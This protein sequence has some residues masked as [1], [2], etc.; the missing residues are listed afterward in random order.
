MINDLTNPSDIRD[1]FVR[2]TVRRLSAYTLEM[3]EAEDKLD[4]NESP[5][6][7]P[8]ELKR[9]IADRIAARPWNM[10]PDFD[11]QRI[12][13]AIA[14]AYGRD[15]QE[16]LA[17]NGSNEL[18]LAALTTFVSPG[19][20]VVIPEP[21]FTLYSKISTIL[22]GDIEPI[23]LDPSLGTL[24]IDA[25]V[26]AVSRSFEESRPPVVIL[27]SPNNPTGGALRD[28]ELDRLLT[29]GALVLLDRAYGEFVPDRYPT[30]HPRLVVFSTFSKAW[31]LAGLRVGWLS[32][33]VELV[34]E[35]RKCKLPYNLNIASEEAA[36]TLLGRPELREENAAFL[37][38]E[39]DRLFEMLATIAGVTPYP[40]F[41]NFVTFALDRDPKEVF[42]G[43]LGKGILVRDVTAYPRL[44]NALR[45]SVGTI[46][47]NDRFVEVLGRIVDE[48]PAQI[49]V[50]VPREELLAP[51]QTGVSVPRIGEM[52]DSARSE[53]PRRAAVRRETKETS[54]EVEV[55]L[56]GTGESDIDTPIGFLSHMLDVIARHG[57]IDLRVH[58]RGDV[59]I[60]YHHTVEDVALVLGEAI[61]TALGD[62]RGIRRFGHAYVPL[63]ESLARVV[64]DFAGRPFLVFD[65]PVDRE[66]L[67]IHKDFPFALVEEFFKSIAN[68]AGCALH[69][70]LIRGRNGH[71]AAEAIFK[72]FAVALRGAKEVVHSTVPST[73]G[74]I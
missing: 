58:A 2:E 12:R 34:A 43:L 13:E 54:I 33:S 15:P 32:G 66:M 69:I 10:Y 70:D 6:D 4:Q 19:T 9:E 68:R 14:R 27:C 23:P 61:A 52:S 17:G 62:K 7:V 30:A 46:E 8:A 64:I 56:D 40:S 31:G 47:Q 16:I 73:K 24:P 63:D 21:T 20:R 74:V 59:E 60:D 36:I 67:L 38:A 42:R 55:D 5:F 35:I 57:R 25:I 1:T 22:G 45:V 18:L 26:A 49:G 50:S 71:H 28:G 44:S 39:R 41:S 72:A 29:T 53:S 51:T 3:R 48:L 37:S 11:L 65:V